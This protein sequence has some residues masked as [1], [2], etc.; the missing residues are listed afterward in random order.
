VE[1]LLLLYELFD[2]ELLVLLVELFYL[3]IYVLFKIHELL[4]VISVYPGIQARH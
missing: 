3:F 4:V 1:L 2:V